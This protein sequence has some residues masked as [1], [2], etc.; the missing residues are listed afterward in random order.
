MDHRHP[1][2]SAPRLLGAHHIAHL[3]PGNRVLSI[4]P[5]RHLSGL[6]EEKYTTPEE[7]HE[8]NRLASAGLSLFLLLAYDTSLLLLLRAATAE[9][10]ARRLG[11]RPPTSEGVPLTC[12]LVFPSNTK[13]LGTSPPA[14][15]AACM[16][17]LPSGERG[18][19]FM[20]RRYY[21]K[22][23]NPGGRMA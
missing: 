6:E 9:N 2:G 15:A 23:R 5:G 16:P 20:G 4:Y 18:R 11:R 8:K 17:L 22:W 19:G 7:L 21:D 14:H 3:G 13:R 10:S 1:T 12:S